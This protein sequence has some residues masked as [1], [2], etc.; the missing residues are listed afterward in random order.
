VIATT[1]GKIDIEKSETFKLGLYQ[2]SFVIKTILTHPLLRLQ[3]LN[4]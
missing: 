4:L 1:I 2:A 3:W